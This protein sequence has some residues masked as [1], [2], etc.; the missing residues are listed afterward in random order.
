VNGLSERLAGLGQPPERIKS[1]RGEEHR[2]DHE[3]HHAR[4]ILELADKGCQQE[5]EG[6]EHQA[7]RQHRRQDRHIAGAVLPLVYAFL[8]SR[9]SAACDHARDREL[10][11]AHFLARRAVEHRDRAPEFR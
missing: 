7:S 2:E 5:S 9:G 1:R 10:D 11:L 6:A 3:V 8:L 4:E